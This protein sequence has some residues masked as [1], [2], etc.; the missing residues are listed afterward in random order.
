MSNARVPKKLSEF[1]TYIKSSVGY[2]QITVGTTTNGARLGLST[3]EMTSAAGYVTSWYTGDPANPG[4]YEKHTN[5]LT[6]SKATRLAVEN[7]M[8]N[9]TVFFNP[10]LV[11]MSGSANITSDARLILHIAEPNPGHRTP[12]S[13]IKDAIFALLSAK[14]GG[15]I[16]VACRTDHD[17]K[18]PSLPKDADGVE[19]GWSIGAE[20][21]TAEASQYFRQFS[22]A[23]FTIA[24]GLANSGKKIY[25][26]VRWI[27]T[28]HPEIAGDWSTVF[29]I[30]IV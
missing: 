8:L 23:K 15:N 4:A 6:K 16:N 29:S 2:L 13:Q 7:I 17:A 19:I 12:Q 18:L 25:V 1:D 22:K 3:T 5:P 27:N 30:M 24:A 9:F 20:P 11:R 28:K 21:P 14:G 10:L 26:H